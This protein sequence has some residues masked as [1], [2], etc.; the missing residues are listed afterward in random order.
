MLRGYNVI[1]DSSTYPSPNRILG[2]LISFGTHSFSREVLGLLG[3]MQGN[4]GKT[5]TLLGGSLDL[6]RLLSNWRYWA[7][8]EGL[9][10]I[11]GR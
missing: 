9:L 2:F 3:S 4:L 1:P 10:G 11:E 7:Y 5:N 6:V 8:N